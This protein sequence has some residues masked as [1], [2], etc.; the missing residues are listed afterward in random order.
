MRIGQGVDVHA[1]AP[2]TGGPLILGGVAIP[3]DR[4]L[5]GHSDGDAALHALTDA[6]LGAAALGDIGTLVG[7]DEPA[8]RGVDSRVFLRAALRQV[9]GQGWC[10]A[11]VDVTILAQ[12]PRLAPHIPAMRDTIAHDLAVASD[13]VSVKA[14]TTDRLGFTGRGEGIAVF[15]VALLAAAHTHDPGGSA[16]AP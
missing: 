13:R 10:V 14:S 15:A 12:R 2:H 7:V 4:S 3:H 5:A 8:T 6:L 11:N 9:R 1:F 16:A